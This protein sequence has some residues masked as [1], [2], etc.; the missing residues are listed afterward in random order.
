MIFYPTLSVGFVS[1][2]FVWLKESQNLQQFNP[3]DSQ[4]FAF[5]KGRL[6]TMALFHVL[7]KFFPTD[8]GKFHLV[9]LFFHILN[10]VLLFSILSHVQL[11]YAFNFMTSLIFLVHFSNEET[12]FWVSSL[13]SIFCL[14]FYLGAVLFYL[15]SLSNS[16]LALK[17]A[18]LGCSLLALSIREDALSIPITL[19]M[20]NYMYKREDGL[21]MLHLL[22]ENFIFLLPSILFL[23]YRVFAAIQESMG[24]EFT[25]NP[26][27]WVQNGLYFILI[28]FVPIRFF[29]DQLGYQVHEKLRLTIMALKDLQLLSVAGILILTVGVILAFRFRNKIPGHVKT[30]IALGMIGFLPYFALVGNAPRFLYFALIGGGIVITHAILWLSKQISKTYFSWTTAFIEVILVGINF[31]VI[32]ERSGWWI[33]SGQTA[34]AILQ[35]TRAAAHALVPRDTLYITNLP[36]R[37]NGAY[38]F[39]NGYPEAISLIAPEIAGKVRFLGNKNLNELKV[40]G[41]KTIYTFEDGKLKKL[42]NL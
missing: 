27:I 5:S 14:F 25:F 21:K 29:F 6:G 15:K 41:V 31:I 23:C 32:Q 33:K 11:P 12:L 16:S 24:Y 8:A 19:V 1:D 37:L 4:S 9:M 10:A 26:T 22:K 34:T 30:G 42:T 13:S 28:L 39:H 38:V 3:L 18:V 2:D 36:R 20:L 40:F 7:Y 17:A 35:Q